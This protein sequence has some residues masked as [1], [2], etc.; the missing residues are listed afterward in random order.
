VIDLIILQEIHEYKFQYIQLQLLIISKMKFEIDDLIIYFPYD[1]I[2]PEQYN[3]MVELKKTL[4]AKGHGVLGK[5]LKI[6]HFID[7]KIDL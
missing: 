7:S 2:Y 5:K 3:Y 4:D 6:N 1:Y